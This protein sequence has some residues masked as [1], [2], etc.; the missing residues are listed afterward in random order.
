MI[1]ALDYHV[2]RWQIFLRDNHLLFTNKNL[3]K[4]IMIMVRLNN[5]FLKERTEKNRKNILNK[6]A[7][8]CLS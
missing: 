6:Q 1:R 7:I 3:S 8:G 5:R 2:S 4:Q